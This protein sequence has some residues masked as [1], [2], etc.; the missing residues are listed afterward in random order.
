MYGPPSNTGCGGGVSIIVE[1]LKNKEQQ[2][3]EYSTKT[4][5]Q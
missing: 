1:T 2:E 4:K 5:D 3:K